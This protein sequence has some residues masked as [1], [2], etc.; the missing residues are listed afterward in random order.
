MAS[1]RAAVASAALVAAMAATS[2]RA[3][4]PSL[5]TVYENAVTTFA[6]TEVASVP[7]STAASDCLGVDAV[8]NAYNGWLVQTNAG[9]V[10]SRGPTTPGCL[11]RAATGLIARAV[12]S[13]AGRPFL[14]RF[15]APSAAFT[16][17]A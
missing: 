3:A 8:D 10:R 14:S 4:P 15:A 2:A 16:T 5:L 7:S 9:T 1:I 13:R 6:G 11:P 12:P 17:A